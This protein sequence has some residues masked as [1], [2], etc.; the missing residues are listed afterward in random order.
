MNAPR[1]PDP[2]PLETDDA[3]VIL[4]GIGLWAVALVVL[5]FAGLDPDQRWWIWTCVAGI[6]LG[7]FGYWYVWR[8]DRHERVPAA[9]DPTG[10]PAL[11][12]ATAGPAQTGAVPREQA[13]T[14]DQEDRPVPGRTS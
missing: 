2:G 4:S 9:G 1:P 3:K 6:G 11:P 10:A 13:V 7:I 12:D 8:R 5:L 14:G